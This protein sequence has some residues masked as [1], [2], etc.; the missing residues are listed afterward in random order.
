MLDT[1]SL[2]RRVVIE[3]WMKV[4]RVHRESNNSGKWVCQEEKAMEFVGMLRGGWTEERVRELE[5]PNRW[6]LR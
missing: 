6:P 5:Y 2:S 4:L 1:C 3:E